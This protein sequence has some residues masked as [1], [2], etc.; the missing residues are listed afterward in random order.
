M[1]YASEV[2][3]DS[4]IFYL[5]LDET[6]GTTAADS[7]GN[8]NDFTYQADVL[9]DQGPLIGDGSSSISVSPS[10][11]A[12]ILSSVPAAFTAATAFTLEAWVNLTTTSQSIN[13][14]SIGNGFDG[15]SMDV[16]SGSGYVTSGNRLGAAAAGLYNVASGVDI[17]TGT[18]HVAVVRNGNTVEFYIDGVQ[19][20]TNGSGWGSVNTPTTQC[21]IGGPIDTLQ[22]SQRIAHAAAYASALSSTRIADHYAAAPPLTSK[23]GR[24]G[25]ALP[26][27]AVQRAA[28]L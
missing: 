17:G 11:S 9:L 28:Y 10:S 6:S 18:H 19:V 3:A 27:Q 13:F 2:I 12:A 7:S 20:A 1:T 25:V 22:P 16:N 8:G 15:Y 21:T 14:I 5:K 24:F 23:V 26:R 4:P